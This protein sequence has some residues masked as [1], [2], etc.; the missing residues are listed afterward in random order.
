VAEQPGEA[1]LAGPR[2]R[3][4]CLIAAAAHD[5]VLD[6][7]WLHSH[8]GPTAQ[9]I[10]RA[11][12]ALV[13]FDPAVL[14]AAGELDLLGPLAQ[15]VCSAMYWQEPWARERLLDT[16]SVHAGLVP[17]A[18]A[19]ADS[20]ATA[21]W[22]GPTDRA[23]QHTVIWEHGGPLVELQ[24][25][26]VALQRWR[27]RLTAEVQR[28]RELSDDLDAPNSGSWWS[29][30]LGHGLLAGARSLA[31]YEAVGLFLVEECQ[32]DFESALVQRLDVDAGARVLEI[33]SPADWVELTRA[34][35]VD[36]TFAR[37][38][39][40]W[41]VSG[42]DGRWLM[43]DWQAVAGEYD[44]VH[45]TVTAYLAGA[46]RALPVDDAATMIAGWDPDATY[47]LTDCARPGGPA[48]RWRQVRG[49]EQLDWVPST[50]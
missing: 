35:P 44:G 10:D 48:R 16:W 12:E 20:T 28:G 18:Q 37:R 13:R 21:W 1:W 34:H 41:R 25:C 3:E 4:L 31:H 27:D 5:P 43:P 11:G 38:H 39:D 42:W 17:I 47:W 6:R 32:G 26:Q 19:L 36:V 7:I 33:V 30:P 8:G 29:S 50:W 2:G 49:G 9:L 14:A 24:P 23:R 45:L 40:W 15:S 46:G 22:S